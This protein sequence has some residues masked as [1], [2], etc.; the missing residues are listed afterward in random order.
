MKTSRRRPGR[1]SSDGLG[2]TGANRSGQTGARSG[3]V[4][5]TRKDD[6]ERRDAPGERCDRCELQKLPPMKAT[7]RSGAKV[8]QRGPSRHAFTRQTV[9]ANLAAKLLSEQGLRA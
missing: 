9:A 2:H 8:Q 1:V 3:R 4:F 5:R 6:N 7:M